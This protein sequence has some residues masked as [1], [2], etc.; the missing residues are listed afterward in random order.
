MKVTRLD[1]DG[2]GSPFGL[3]TKILKIESDLK[4][5]VPIDELAQQ[6]DIQRIEEFETEGFEGG[7]LTD[8]GRSTG[9]ILVNKSARGGRR[10]FTIGHELAHFLIL[11]HAPVEP[12]KFLCSRADMQRWDV[13]QNDRYKR[14]E[15]EAN[16]FS[17]LILMP[18]PALRKFIEA[19]RNPDI[20]HAL[21]TANHFDVSKEAGARAYA[22]YHDEL[23]A[24]VVVN[25][26]KVLRVHKHRNFPRMSV[27]RLD[28]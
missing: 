16:K 28:E 25:E 19:K 12:G 3:V 2:T 23:V 15:A 7:L 22:E 11:S 21:E 8:E 10:R 9:I 13:N 27:K 18:P 14:M 17:A 4:I 26:N 24:I 1:L 5:P 6:L 20:A